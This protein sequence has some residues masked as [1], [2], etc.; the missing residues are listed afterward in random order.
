[1]EENVFYADPQSADVLRSA[2]DYGLSHPVLADP[3]MS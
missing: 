2:N 3:S 1:M